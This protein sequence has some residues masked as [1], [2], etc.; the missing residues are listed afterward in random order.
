MTQTQ[1]SNIIN[2]AFHFHQSMGCEIKE[3]SPDYIEEK[4]S[5]YFG[6]KPRKITSTEISMLDQYI[7]FHEWKK[8][9]RC[10]YLDHLFF[11]YKLNTKRLSTKHK[12]GEMIWKPSELISLFEECVGDPNMI[13]NHTYNGLHHKIKYSVKDWESNEEIIKDYKSVIRDINID[14]ILS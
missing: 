5:Y 12:N 7:Q 14:N 3:F 11:I 13:I 6:V 9:W 10:E 1:V 2:F 8:T 4:F